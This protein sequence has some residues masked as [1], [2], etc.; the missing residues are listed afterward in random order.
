MRLSIKEATLNGVM[1]LS[2]SPI[3]GQCSPGWDLDTG[4][5]PLAPPNS[6]TSPKSPL[7]MIPCNGSEVN[8]NWATGDSS[9]GRSVLDSRSLKGYPGSP[10]PSVVTG[11]VLDRLQQ[12]TMSGKKKLVSP[13]LSLSMD[14]SLSEEMKAL[15]GNKLEVLR[16]MASLMIFPPTYLFVATANSNELLWTICQQFQWSGLHAFFGDPQRQVKAGERGL[17]PGWML[18]LR[19]LDLSGGAAI[20]VMK[21]LC[22]MNFVERSTCPTYCAGQIAIRSIWSLREPACQVKLKRSGSHRTLNQKNGTQVW[23]PT[24]LPLCLED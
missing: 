2:T 14:D 13:E 23:T 17:K 18:T 11:N 9:I 12:E 1:P 15:I 16:K 21:T 7:G 6:P 3:N 4:L 8:K 19:I 22:L 20:E 5:E 10:R 24:P